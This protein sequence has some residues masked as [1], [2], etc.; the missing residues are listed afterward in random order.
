MQVIQASVSTLLQWVGLTLGSR[1]PADESQRR[2]VSVA[3]G[4]SSALV[5]RGLAALT[6]FLIV[7]LA[8]GYL[9]AE[10]Y[11]AWVTISST[12]TWLSVADFGLANGLTHA[13]S[14]AY[15]RGRADLARQLVA[16]S[17]W[18]LAS[19]A[20]LCA[21]LFG[22]FWLRVD[23]AS[24]LNTTALVRTE[25]AR[26]V[27]LAVLLALASFPL[28]VVDRIYASYEEGALSNLW[29]AAASLVSLVAV[30]LATRTGGGMVAV[31]AAYSGGRFAILLGNAVWLFAI[32]RV[33]VRPA[34]S[35]VAPKT[36]G[37][38]LRSGGL[39][40]VVQIAALI[41]FNTDNI[42]IARVLGA[43]SVTPY[44]VTWTL[45][46]LPS[47]AITLAFP[48]LWPAY[49]H[50]IARGDV[51]WVRRTFRIS[52]LVA[53][54]CAVALALPLAVFGKTLIALWVG[55]VAVPSSALL[56]WMGVWSVVNAGMNALACLLNAARQ[57]TGQAVYGIVTAALNLVLSI[58][59]ARSYGPAGVIAATVAAY[60]VCAVIPS[61]IETAR[62]LARLRAAGELR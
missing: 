27:G 59:W 30:V 44:A 43:G 51:R 36:A 19:I 12:I 62:L 15:G 55:K 29:S 49:T 60:V 9:G 22:V 52:L 47:M 54:G 53:A 6:G 32:H 56:T 38:L 45:F 41:L 2:F 40:F 25:V 33:D 13:L 46:T 37:Q 61:S 5:T 39:F 23:W 16:T 4:A 7:P 24:T 3:R 11:G 17:F 26:A 50:A 48:Y 14:D 21:L 20:L 57:V 1:G 35:A 31:V 28:S 18:L 58:A 42:I 10:R 8:V 34:F